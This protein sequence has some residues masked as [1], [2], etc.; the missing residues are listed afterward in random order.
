MDPRDDIAIPHGDEHRQGAR[1]RSLMGENH[2]FPDFESG[3]FFPFHSE[4][5]VTSIPAVP[6]KFI[7]RQDAQVKSLVVT[8]FDQRHVRAV[9][10]QLGDFGRRRGARS[11]DDRLLANSRRQSCQGCTR[12]TGGSGNEHPRANFSRARNDQ[13]AGA[14][15]ERSGRVAAFILE[16]QPGQARLFH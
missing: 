9:H 14:I 8:A 2:V 4:R 5:I 16:P 7:R 1:Q 3:G 12:I 15:F 13:R 10:Q 11:Q 6:A